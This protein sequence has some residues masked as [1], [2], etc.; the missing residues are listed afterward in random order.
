V[1]AFLTNDPTTTMDL[2]LAGKISAEKTEIGMDIDF[3]FE[4]GVQCKVGFDFMG[5]GR[6][7]NTTITIN[8]FT[9]GKDGVNVY[10]FAPYDIEPTAVGG[11]TLT[12]GSAEIQLIPELPDAECF[13]VVV[14][15]DIGGDIVTCY[16][17]NTQFI[18]EGDLYTTVE[19]C[20]VGGSPEVPVELDATDFVPFSP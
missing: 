20:I 13:D 6:N 5:P 11:G 1:I 7:H 3:D 4:I 9:S 2:A 16:E 15:L 14:W 18:W 10:A 17:E 19:V 12:G 8:G